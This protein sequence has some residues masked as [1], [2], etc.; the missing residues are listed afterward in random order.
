VKK[1][2]RLEEVKNVRKEERKKETKDAFDVL[3]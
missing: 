3:S 1:E 2:V